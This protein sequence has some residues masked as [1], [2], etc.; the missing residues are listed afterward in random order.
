MVKRA[1]A[2]ITNKS[3]MEMTMS[4]YVEQWHLTLP[5]DLPSGKKDDGE[6]VKHMVQ[7]QSGKMGTRCTNKDPMTRITGESPR[8]K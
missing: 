3:I 8:S 7:T 5:F 4:L 6:W 1:F 2:M